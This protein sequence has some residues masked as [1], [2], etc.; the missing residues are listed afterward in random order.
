MWFRRGKKLSSP[1]LFAFRLT[2]H[3]GYA[4]PDYLLDMLTAQQLMEWAEY[5][6]HVGL[7]GSGRQYQ[8]LAI[9]TCAIV[10]AL[11]GSKT[12]PE[13]FLPWFDP[14]LEDLT[15]DELAAKLGIRS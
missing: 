9:N 12:K 4:H 2:E 8:Q 3:L 1:R 7:L 5:E 14:Y 13:D 6:K 11:T 15:A 10:N